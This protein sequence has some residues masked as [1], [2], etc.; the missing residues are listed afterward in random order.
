MIRFCA[1]VLLSVGPAFGQ[2][3]PLPFQLETASYWE[4]LE[5]SYAKIRL[6]ISYD[7]LLFVKSTESFTAGYS[8]SYRVVTDKGERVHTGHLSGT[9][10]VF[11]FAETNRRNLFA[12]EELRLKLPPGKY[13]LSV[14]VEDVENRRSGTRQQAL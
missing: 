11:S 8:A 4:P 12:N 1:F 10:Q 2:S 13:V 3:I 6:S 9:V 5:G 7:E 14:T